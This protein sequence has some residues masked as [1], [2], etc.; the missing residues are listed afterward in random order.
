MLLLGHLVKVQ[1]LKGEFLLNPATDSPERIPELNGLL[2]APPDLNLSEYNETAPAKQVT[3][4][5]FR[6]HQNR[7]CLAFDQIPDRTAAE[8]F[9]NWGLWIPEIAVELGEGESYRHDWVGCQVFVDNVLVGQVLE[10]K[11]S[12]AGYDMVQMKDLR[13]GCY[14]IRDVPYIKAWFKL[15]LRKR[16]IDLEP[17][18]GLLDV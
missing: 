16:R 7:P 14:G 1:G 11:P 10:L 12:P 9:K 4:R 5:V 18:N 8:P 15:D 13:P 6:W 2:L 3:V 17:P